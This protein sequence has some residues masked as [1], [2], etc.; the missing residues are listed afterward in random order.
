[1]GIA[2]Q[3]RPEQLVDPDAP[4]AGNLS[5][6]LS[7]ASHALATELTARL[8]RIGIF[9]RGHCVLT[10]ALNGERTQTEIAHAIGLDKTTMVVTLD[11]L[12][13]AGLAERRLSETDRRARKITVTPAGRRKVV[14]AERVVAEV[15]EEILGTLPASERRALVSG[16]AKLV[17]GRLS[18]PAQCG[19]SVR[20]RD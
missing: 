8:E 3:T 10:A 6:L 19:R 16:L 11:E 2:T 1:M 7:Q 14:E 12:E 9:P 20:R 13:Q 4:L 5:W 18:Q 15:Q 17:E